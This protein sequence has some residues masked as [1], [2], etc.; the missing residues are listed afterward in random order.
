MSNSAEQIREDS[1]EVERATCPICGRDRSV[2]MLRKSAEL[3][4]LVVRRIEGEH[5]EWSPDDGVCPA[6]V[7]V[8]LQALLRLDA[9][10]A[11]EAETAGVSPDD[12]PDLIEDLFVLPTP[13]RLQTWPHVTGR[14]VTIAFVD[15]GFFDHPDLVEPHDRVAVRVD[16]RFDPPRIVERNDVAD[17]AC[18]HGLMTTVVAAGNGAFSRGHYRGLAP[19][20]RLVLVRVGDPETGTIGEAEIARGLAWLDENAESYGVRVVN[21]S[22][23]GDYP[24]PSDMNLVDSLVERLVGRGIA[25]VAASGNEGRREIVPPASAPSAITVGGFD[26]ATDRTRR[27]DSLVGMPHSPKR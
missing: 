12:L 27:I 20:A 23:G 24:S 26:D 25:V 13:M 4:P 9:P 8:A 5:A 7:Q 6:C 2:A 19:D 14:G 22:L 3:D 18:F 15:A 11:L 16:A 10:F 17:P 21:V 1:R